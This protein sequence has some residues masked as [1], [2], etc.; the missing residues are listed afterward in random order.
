MDD[1]EKSEVF[2]IDEEIK[3]LTKKRNRLSRSEMTKQELSKYLDE[4]INQYLP[5]DHPKPLA[6][7]SIKLYSSNARWFVN[8][9]VEDDEII[10]NA[11]SKRLRE[12]LQKNYSSTNTIRTIMT[13]VSKFLV[14]AGLYDLRIKRFKSAESQA[15]KHVIDLWE[16]K[17]LQSRA[18]KLSRGSTRE[19]KVYAEMVLV[20]RTIAYCGIRIE[21]RQFITLDN[22]RKSPDITFPFKGKYKTVTIRE[23]IRQELIK[24]AEEND[25]I[26]GSVF[27]LNGDAIR[28]RLKLLARNCKINPKKIHPHAFRHFF[29]IQYLEQGGTIQELKQLLGHAQLATTSIYLEQTQQNLR[30]KLNT[31][32]LD[33]ADIG[34]LKTDTGAILSAYR[35]LVYAYR[36]TWTKKA[37]IE[38]LTQTLQQKEITK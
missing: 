28:Y 10:T 29:A 22:L 8:E 15:I 23:N 16:F 17:R 21:E 4:Y 26:E 20:L 32:Q 31:L 3:F 6:K 37:A 18:K 36:N 2:H 14:F 12:Y 11:T 33:E 25:L 9:F 13:A 38:L 1:R 19:A 5:I 24:H 27:L 34:S 35:E 7:G 30:S